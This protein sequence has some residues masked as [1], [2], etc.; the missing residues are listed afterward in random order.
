MPAVHIYPITQVKIVPH[1]FFNATGITCL[2]QQ[3]HQYIAD[4]MAGCTGITAWYIRNTIMYHSMFYKS[5]MLVCSDLAGF[6]T[7]AA[8]NTYINNHTAGAHGFN[9]FFSNNNRAS[10]ALVG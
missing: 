9:H 8:V 3:R 10:A 7:A 6:K 1:H 4:S 5:W 2:E